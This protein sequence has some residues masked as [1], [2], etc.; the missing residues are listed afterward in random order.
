[1]AKMS[2]GKYFSKIDCMSSIGHMDAYRCG[3][4][5][6][7]YVERLEQYFIA[8]EIGSLA[9]GADDTAEARETAQRKKVVTFS[10]VGWTGSIQTAEKAQQFRQ[11]KLSRN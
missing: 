4:D 9:V 1:M 2:N 7:D 3:D 11:A 8:N 5:L 6:D 10:N